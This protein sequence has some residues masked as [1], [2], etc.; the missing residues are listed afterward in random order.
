MHRMTEREEGFSLI[1]LLVVMLILGVVGAVTLTGLV[2]GMRTSEH[3]QAR[4]DALVELE[5]AGQRLEREL[6]RGMWSTSLTPSGSQPK[7]CVVPAV[8]NAGNASSLR[9]ND[10]S[11]VALHSGERYRYR[12]TLADGVVRMAEAR[13][14][15]TGWDPIADRVVIA[16]VTNAAHGIPLLTYLGADGE[17]L[18]PSVGEYTNLHIAQL[19]K[20]RLR[21]RLDVRGEE[22]IELSTLVAPRNGGGRCPVL[23]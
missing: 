21:L 5:R 1:E 17:Q 3:V 4:T 12:I 22:P 19:R 6:R 14:D 9:G 18:V 10:L 11:L 20:Y 13:W 8:N 7:G 15:G 23:D 16:G 2:R